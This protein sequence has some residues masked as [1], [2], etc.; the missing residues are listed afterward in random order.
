MSKVK[1][2]WDNIVIYYGPEW[3]QD[4][5]LDI[6]KLK[7]CI[8]VHVDG[9]KEVPKCDFCIEP[10]SNEWCPAKEDK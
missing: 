8:E 3:D 10:C 1:N 5:P 2:F 6:P 9:V 7:E 4:V